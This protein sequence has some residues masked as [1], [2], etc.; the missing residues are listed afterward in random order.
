[1]TI[2]SGLLFNYRDA[3]RIRQQ[4]IEQRQKHLEIAHRNFRR[5]AVTWLWCEAAPRQKPRRSS[6]DYFSTTVMLFA[7]GSR[8]LKE[9]GTT[10]KSPT[11]NS[12]ESA[13]T[14]E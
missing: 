4:H 1:M 2:A 10:S 11:V 12:G 8:T 3:L 13:V 6:H 14:S 9:A 5:S 7:F